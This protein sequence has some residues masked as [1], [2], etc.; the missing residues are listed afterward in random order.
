MGRPS[1]ICSNRAV[2]AVSGL[3]TAANAPENTLG[4]RSFSMSAPHIRVRRAAPRATPKDS[5]VPEVGS[6]DAA[7]GSQAQSSY[8]PAH[9]THKGRTSYVAGNP[10]KSCCDAQT[11]KAGAG[12]RGWESGSGKGMRRLETRISRCMKPPGPPRSTRLLRTPLA[13][14]R[15][16]TRRAQRSNRESV[17]HLYPGLSAVSHSNAATGCCCRTRFRACLV[18]GAWAWPRGRFCAAG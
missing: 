1:R 11:V 2:G 15:T 13:P 10:G 4:T 16:S 9:A 18:A 17:T 8:A 14:P 5:K 7:E 12:A 6:P 3:W